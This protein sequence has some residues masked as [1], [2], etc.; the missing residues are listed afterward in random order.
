METKRAED[1]HING[2]VQEAWVEAEIEYGM[3]D[4]EDNE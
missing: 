1:R 3:L 2:I 4:I